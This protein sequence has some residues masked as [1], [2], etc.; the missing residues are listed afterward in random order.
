MVSEENPTARELEVAAARSLGPVAGPSTGPGDHE[1]LAMLARRGFH[2]TRTRPD[3][4]WDPAGLSE[5]AAERVWDALRHYALRL[6][7]RGAIQR[8]EGFAP[9]DA[10]RF[11]GAR[12]AEALASE[13][14]ELGLAVEA[15]PGRYRLVHPPDSFGGTLEWFVGRALERTLGFSV[16]VGVKFHAPGVGGDLDV[17]AAAEG[18]LVY[19]ELKSSP[20]KHLKPAEVGAFFDRV[21]CLRPHVSLFVVDTALRL[22]DR[23]LPMLLE[24]A[25]PGR[26]PALGPLAP[27]RVEREL[28]ALTPHVYVVNAKPDLVANVARAIAEGFAALAPPTP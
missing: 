17:V 28:W 18:K 14:V 2:S 12:H 6:L 10:T 21:R 24:A 26:D 11:L 7:L 27:R 23:V 3:L 13:L 9:E 5:D 16:A 22:G 19:L 1:A 25:A 8:P 4:P 15:P 20:P